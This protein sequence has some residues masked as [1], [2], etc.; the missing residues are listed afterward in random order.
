VK[1]N[2]S[3][4]VDKVAADWVSRLKLKPIIGSL[5]PVLTNK[6]DIYIRMFDMLRRISLIA[7]LTVT[8]CSVFAQY[9]HPRKEQ[10]Q[11]SSRDGRFEGSVILAYQN[12]IKKSNEGGS[13]VDVDS[14]AGWG[15]SFAWNWTEKWNV[16]YRLISTSPKYSAL[17]VPEDPDVVPRTINHKMSKYSHQLNVTYN[18][19][20][21]AFT[22]FVAAGIGWTKLDSNVPSAPPQT[23]CWWDPWWG[24]IC[25]SDWK[26]YNA[27]EFTYNLGAGVRWDINNVL[28][29]KAAYS[30]EFLDVKN[31]SIN[32]DMAI[33]ELGLMF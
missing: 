6:I 7:L 32:F 4:I 15:I 30:R 25:I 24:Y 20:R 8:S 28:Y 31:G 5:C 21:K 22:P 18:F 19:S 3:R 33:L 14:T 16:S 2:L 29:T 12:G 26:T 17:I 13:E 1:L 23:G 11:A 27:S 10:S 9:D